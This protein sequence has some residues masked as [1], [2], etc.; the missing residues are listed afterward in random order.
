MVR[1][2][3]SRRCWAHQGDPANLVVYV[4]RSAL[5]GGGHELL[6]LVDILWQYREQITFA[7]DMAELAVAVGVVAL[8]KPYLWL[9]K[10]R[11]KRLGREFRRR[12]YTTARVMHWVDQHG[13][14]W[15][16]RHL[17]VRL[18]I[19]DDESR[20]MLYEMGW[21]PDEHG[22]FVRAD[23]A[24]AVLRRAIIYT[25]GVQSPDAAPDDPI[26]V[27]EAWTWWDAPAYDDETS[28]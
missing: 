23:D 16:A 19:T 20:A 14:R 11:V 5:G 1:I 15:D 2:Y 6:P 4:D 7:K 22:L 25:N 17:A 27:S 24:E 12:G 21:R 9:T 18:G 3:S 13:A 26:V 28:A 8:R 10:D